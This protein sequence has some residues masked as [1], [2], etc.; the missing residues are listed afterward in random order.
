M[1]QRNFISLSE[2]GHGTS[3][4]SFRRVRLHLRKISKWVVIMAMKTER[5]QIHFLSDVFATVASS[6]L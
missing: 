2:L 1:R 4:F 3:E 6:D 5:M